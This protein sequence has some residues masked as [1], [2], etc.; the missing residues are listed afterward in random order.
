MY[1]FF[2][3]LICAGANNSNTNHVSEMWKSSSYPLYRAIVGIN[4][5]KSILCFIHFDESNTR[6]QRL[7][8][9]KTAPIR[10]MEYAEDKFMMYKPTENLTIDEQLFFFRGR[11][12]F[13]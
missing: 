6:Q 5:F 9:N 4:R 8:E 11:T 13:T 2:D 12:K 10:D 7:R 1:A 3:I